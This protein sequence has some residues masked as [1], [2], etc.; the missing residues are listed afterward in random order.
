MSKT[1]IAFISDSS[2]QTASALQQFKA[3][4]TPFKHQLSI[5]VVGYSPSLN[6]RYFSMLSETYA[7]FI[8]W[9]RLLFKADYRIMPRTINTCQTN[10]KI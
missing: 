10:G 8:E 2:I 5:T 6:S 1:T 7:N 3:Q 4:L 9:W